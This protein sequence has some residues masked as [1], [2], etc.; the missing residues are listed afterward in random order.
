MASTSSPLVP[1]A[2]G[3]VAV[4]AVWAMSTGTAAG[5]S[6]GMGLAGNT[7]AVKWTNSGWQGIAQG[8]TQDMT[9]PYDIA[10]QT[11]RAVFPFQTWPTTASAPADRRALWTKIQ[12]D[13][14]GFLSAPTQARFVG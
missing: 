7:D 13:V 1:L 3:L 5:K 9:D 10:V 12:L 2:I 14:G 4:G 8:L 6:V 11:A